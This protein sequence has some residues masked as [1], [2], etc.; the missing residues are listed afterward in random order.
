MP[1]RPSGAPV[2]RTFAESV[3]TRD[4]EKVPIA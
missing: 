1:P 3:T 4:I 2:V